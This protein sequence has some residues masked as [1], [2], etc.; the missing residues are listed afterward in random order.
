MENLK[1]M[2]I[3]DVDRLVKQL[4]CEIIKEEIIDLINVCTTY[5]E[6]RNL[7]HVAEILKIKNS[8]DYLKQKKIMEFSQTIY[9]TIINKYPLTNQINFALEIETEGLEEMKI[10]I[11]KNRQKYTD[12][13]ILINQCETIENL[14][15]IEED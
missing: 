5:E 6:T 3:K 9:E 1:K 15:K 13:K 4:D 7:D 11:K 8:L 12:K 2:K 10:F 14:N